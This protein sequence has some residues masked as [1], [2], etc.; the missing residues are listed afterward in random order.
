MKKIS[1]ILIGLLVLSLSASSLAATG[2]TKSGSYNTVSGEL[3]DGDP[4]AQGEFSNGVSFTPKKGEEFLSVKID[5]RSGLPVRAIVVQ[6]KE[7]P[8]GPYKVLEEE[9]CGRTKSPIRI[10]PG[11]DVEVLVQDGLCSD[12]TTGAATFGTVTATFR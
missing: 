8:N 2:R 1:V 10:K 12:G 7:S 9:I 5:D 4:S 3:T 6:S 11:L